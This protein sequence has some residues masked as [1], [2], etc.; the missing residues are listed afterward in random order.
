MKFSHVIV[1][2]LVLMLLLGGCSQ[3]APVEKGSTQGALKIKDFAGRTLSF[4][5]SPQR[6]VSLSTGDM[7]IIYALGGEVVGRPTTEL[8][9]KL[10]K[11]KS[12]QTIGTTHQYDVELLTSLKPDVVLGNEQLNSKDISTIEGIGSQLLLTSAN[13]VK[14]I[15]R[16]ISLFGDLL[17]KQ[18]KA[19]ALNEQIDQR[20]K[21]VKPPKKK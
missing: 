3:A 11:A 6:I 14:D 17:E 1:A 7:S 18:Q 16:Q 5:E 13:S 2:G 15:Q 9:D 4:D 20:K 8:P 19:K 10:Q 12:V 21:Q